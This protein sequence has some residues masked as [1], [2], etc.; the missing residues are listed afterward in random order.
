MNN[1]INDTTFKV[2]ERPVQMEGLVN[3]DDYK[4]II[5]NDTNEV[6]SC[7]TK[8]YQLV[9]NE[10]VLEKALPH[11]EERNGTLTECKTFG[12]GARTSWTFKF[13]D[14]PMEISGDTLYPQLHIRNSYD[15]TSAVNI[16]GGIFRLVCANGAIIGKIFESHSE[17]HSIWN[18]KIT[19][20][21]IGN[22]VLNTLDSME[23]VYV[24]EFPILFETKI[25]DK[26]IVKALEKLPSQYNEDA[27]NYLLAN[28]VKTAWDLFNMFTWIYTHRANRNHETTHK[29]ET[30]AYN[31]VRKLAQA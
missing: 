21:H 8:D 9:S 20:G 2:I 19:N 14:Q 29:L 26:Q 11:I 25:N 28:N 1:I 31:Y 17:K 6:L 5:R 27:V 24:N 22:M 12:N 13:K 30:D 23:N 4:L 18:R 16:L 3:A 7:M 15:G 10:E